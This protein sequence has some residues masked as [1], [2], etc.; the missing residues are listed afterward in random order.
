M[1]RDLPHPRELLDA[2]AWLH[3]G[4]PAAALGIDAR[5]AVLVLL[6]LIEA[7]PALIPLYCYGTPENRAAMTE[8]E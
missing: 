6:Q 1:S 3:A 4:A 8:S 2:R 5:E 7:L